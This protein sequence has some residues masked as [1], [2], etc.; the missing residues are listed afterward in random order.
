MNSSSPRLLLVSNEKSSSH[1]ITRTVGETGLLGL[2][3]S[4]SMLRT[5]SL[6]LSVK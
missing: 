3:P 2:F 6:A 1:S 5:F 4:F